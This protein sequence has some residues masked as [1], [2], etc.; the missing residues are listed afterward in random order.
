MQP[1][2]AKL[3]L[4]INTASK[5]LKTNGSALECTP[6]SSINWL[7]VH[8]FLIYFALIMI[9]LEQFPPFLTA[10]A[11]LAKIRLQITLLLPCI[12]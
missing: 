5:E 11:L 7:S 2:A 6:S 12:A 8:V 4:G 9:V 10:Q 1:I 3:T